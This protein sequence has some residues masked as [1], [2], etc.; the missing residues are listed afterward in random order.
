MAHGTFY[1]SHGNYAVVGS[2]RYESP[3]RRFAFAATELDWINFQWFSGY[4]LYGTG[5][6]VDDV[7]ALSVIFLPLSLSL[8]SPLLIKSMKNNFFLLFVLVFTPSAMFSANR[9]F[10]PALAE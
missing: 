1:K 9:G 8:L 10:S 3:S 6:C 5:T 7:D 2:C 4:T